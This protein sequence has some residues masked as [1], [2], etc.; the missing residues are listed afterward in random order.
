ML[1][2]CRIFGQQLAGFHPRCQHGRASI[3]KSMIA[4]TRPRK[5]ASQMAIST[6]H[7]LS[8][9]VGTTRCQDGESPLFNEVYP[10]LQKCYNAY[11][12]YVV[13]ERP[14]ENNSFRRHQHA[15]ASRE[16]KPSQANGQSPWMDT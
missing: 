3:E 9:S 11:N 2:S 12:N 14:H 15:S 13:E 4:R 10:P 6:T 8:P 1:D 7:E 5:L 16:R